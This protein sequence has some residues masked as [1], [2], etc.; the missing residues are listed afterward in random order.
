MRRLPYRGKSIGWRGVPA[1]EKTRA[2]ADSQ[3]FATL[4]DLAGQTPAPRSGLRNAICSLL[5]E[6]RAS[7][8]S[9]SITQELVGDAGA[10]ASSPPS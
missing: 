3:V 8:G 2:L 1:R 10:Q 6:A 9:I 5:L 4:K 7:E